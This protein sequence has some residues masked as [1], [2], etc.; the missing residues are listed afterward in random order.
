MPRYIDGMVTNSNLAVSSTS[1]GTFNNL[2][3]QT[4]SATSFSISS[5]SVGQNAV[6]GTTTFSVNMNLTYGAGAIASF[7]NPSTTV[8]NTGNI[9]DLSAISIK[10]VSMIGNVLQTIGDIS[11]LYI[12]GGSSITNATVTGSQYALK[13]GSGNSFFG[14]NLTSTGTITCN[15]IVA[16]TATFTG[17]LSF[18]TPISITDATNSTSSA[19]GCL[20]LS[21]GAGIAKDV[22]IAGSLT[23]AS[24]S[25]GTLN[26]TNLTLA[27]L[28]ATSSLTAANVTISSGPLVLSCRSPITSG[29]P[30][31]I[32]FLG[33][34]SFIIIPINSAGPFSVTVPSGT[35]GQMLIL[36]NIG[37]GTVS[38]SINIDSQASVIDMVTGA[39]MSMIW[40]GTWLSIV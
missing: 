4:L 16:N 7:N 23:C 18:S 35:N 3:A 6:I 13:V 22:N 29:S 38:V 31:T 27:S 19:T 33:A 15:S 11:T 36:L 12:S 37:V 9:A 20:I 34:D 2:T 32:N 39:K 8:L 1:D 5:L 28:T 10:G 14:G 24:L 40:Y 17:G 26:L 30:Y 21:G 25:T